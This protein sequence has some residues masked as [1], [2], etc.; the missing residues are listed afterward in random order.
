MFSEFV[1][2]I[3]KHDYL[4]I[5]AFALMAATF[6][7]Y[8]ILVKPREGA[9]PPE[10]WPIFII[11]VAFFLVVLLSSFLWEVTTRRGRNITFLDKRDIKKNPGIY[12][13]HSRDLL[14]LEFRLSL[15][16][17]S[18]EIDMLGL[19]LYGTW[20]EFPEIVKT[21]NSRLHEVEKG[22]RLRIILPSE[23]SLSM[24]ALE[25]DREAHGNRIGTKSAA[26]QF[27]QRYKA[28]KECLHNLLGGMEQDVL[29]LLEK[30]V[31]FSGVLRFDEVMIVTH[32][33]SAYRGS[34][35]P[36]LI[37]HKEAKAKEGRSLF[38]SYADE[39]G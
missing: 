3:K 9:E 32:Y 29:R 13:K 28:T 18:T 36:A 38:R 12:Y 27:I 35:S 19:N 30:E 24:R 8:Y 20:F 14:G 25:S 37:L 2:F 23:D 33:L 21:F 7:V 1:L 31:V 15:V 11:W 5:P 4:V 17:Q 39:F 26:E 16:K 6:V 34:S 22:F 10:Y